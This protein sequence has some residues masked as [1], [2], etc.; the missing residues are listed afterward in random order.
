MVI[1][2]QGP[3]S[4]IELVIRISDHTVLQ[5]WNQSPRLVYPEPSV[6]LPRVIKDSFHTLLV[7]LSIRL[8]STHNQLQHNKS[9]LAQFPSG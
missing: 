3:C 7:P 4:E 1:S 8:L 6:S 2:S 5:K 9:V